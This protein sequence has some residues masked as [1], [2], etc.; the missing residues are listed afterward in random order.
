MEKRTEQFTPHT[1]EIVRRTLDKLDELGEPKFYAVQVDGQTV[2]TRTNNPSEVD[3]VRGFLFHN[4]NQLRIIFYKGF[5][6]DAV[7]E[8]TYNISNNQSNMNGLS[9]LGEIDER[10]KQ[11]VNSERRN[12]EHELLKKE[13]SDAKKELGDAEDHIESL[14]NLIDELKSSKNKLG[15]IH[16]GEVVSVMVES[17]MRRNVDKIKKLPGGTTLAGILADNSSNASSEHS[18]NTE[19]SFEKVNEEDS[20]WSD[21]ESAFNEK[22]LD[23]IK[24]IVAILAGDKTKITTVLSLLQPNTN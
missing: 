1:L 24:A 14:E 15:N 7:E 10:I 21:V 12:W 2:V 8:I 6:G 18:E 22:E 5:D 17:F 19:A 9:G 13:L 3:R 16:V 23:C 20:W 11:A 4:S